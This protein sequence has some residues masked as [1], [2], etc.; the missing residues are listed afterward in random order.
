M[1]S[2]F[3]KSSV[4]G[5]LKYGKFTENN[6]NNYSAGNGTSHQLIST[7]NTSN[8]PAIEKKS[9]KDGFLSIRKIILKLMIS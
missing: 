1:G 5:N 8:Q 6:L 2:G 4:D 3:C 9:G 7:G